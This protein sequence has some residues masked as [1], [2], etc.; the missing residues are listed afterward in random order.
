MRPWRTLRG[1]VA[2]GSLI[3]LVTA[4]VVFAAVGSG[5]IR[6]QTEESAR[7]EL[8]RQTEAMAALV[9]DRAERAAQNG[10]EF[11]IFRPANLERLVGPD[12]RLYFT[13]LG[14]SPGAERPNDLLPPVAAEQ[15]SYEALAQD[16]I[17]RIDF[18]APGEPPA[19][20]SAAPVTVGGE[21]VGAIVLARPP[22]QFSAAWGDLWQRVMIATLAGL[23]VAIGLSL[24]LADRVTRP[25]RRFQDATRQVA[26]G[27]LETR[28]EPA[29]TQELDEVASG[30]NT[31]VAELAHKDDQSRDFLMRVTH[32]LRTPLTAI[33]GHAAALS[34]GVVPEEQVGR[35]LSAIESEA[36]RLET[37]VSDLLD[38]A[39]LDAH[40]FRLELTEVEPIEILDVAMAALETR[41]EEAGVAIELDVPDDLPTIETDIVRVRQIVCNLLEN[42]VRWSP[43]GGVVHL[44]ARTIRQ[45][46]V[47][48]VIDDGPGVPAGDRA[49]IFEPF[50][51]HETPRGHCGTGLG[52]AISRQLARALGGDLELDTASPAGSTFRLTLPLA[53]PT[54][55]DVNKRDAPEQTVAERH[56]AGATQVRSSLRPACQ[57]DLE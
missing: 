30:F 8:D 15:I 52:L 42:A 39:R 18:E 47:V 20:A 43:S 7:G 49:K 2:L 5:L 29:G 32:D 33:R 17:Q 46:L 51:S 53:S 9:S 22:S 13:G 10:M 27:D 37:L 56:N 11:Q 19:E 40:Q 6:S 41:A 12:S 45:R 23:I 44:W 31:M 36:E 14:L 21:T 55:P 4:A 35:S 1:R 54:E 16:G 34:D 24:Y 25:L 48:E 28:L 57:V 26:G 38:L 50:Y 3:G